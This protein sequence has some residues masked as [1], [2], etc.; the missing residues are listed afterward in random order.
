MVGLLI[1]RRGG[2]LDA[3]TGFASSRGAAG[4]AALSPPEPNDCGPETP[5]SSGIRRCGKGIDKLAKGLGALRPRYRS[6]A[7]TL[8]Q[9]RA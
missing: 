1:R 5:I 6:L 8:E 4:L 3:E 2:I 9:A 7:E